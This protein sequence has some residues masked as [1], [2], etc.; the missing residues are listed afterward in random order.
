MQNYH[1]SGG[2]FQLLCTDPQ[3]CTKFTL[4]TDDNYQKGQIFRHS[5][6]EGE[7]SELTINK[8]RPRD[9]PLF[10]APVLYDR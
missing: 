8:N 9:R 2:T 5:S 3:S 7:L 10:I 1:P 4:C 6:Y